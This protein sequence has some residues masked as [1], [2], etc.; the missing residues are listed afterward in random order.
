[1]TSFFESNLA[2]EVFDQ[3]FATGIQTAQFSTLDDTGIRLSDIDGGY[4][5]E[6]DG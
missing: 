2:T 6:E 4:S 5:G 3:E 1:M